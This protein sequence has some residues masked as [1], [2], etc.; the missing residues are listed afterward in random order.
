RASHDAGAEIDAKVLLR[1]E[2][3]IV[4]YPRPTD[5]FAASRE[6]FCDERAVD[7]AAI[8]VQLI[9][10]DKLL[11]EVSAQGWDCFVLGPI[12]RQNRARQDESFVEVSGDMTFVAIE[13]L[14]LALATVPHVG[15]LDGDSPIGSRPLANA[16]PTA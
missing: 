9:G 1:E 7:V 4:G 15:I 10:L 13:E 14:G 12:R 16:R 3:V 6:H 8:D 2:P 5:H 11:R